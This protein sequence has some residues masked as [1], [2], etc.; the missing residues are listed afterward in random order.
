MSRE[1]FAEQ[2]MAAKL[3]VATLPVQYATEPHAD[4]R[5]VFEV[6]ATYALGTQEYNTFET[7]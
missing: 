5:T 1:D 4:L 7:H 3:L 6:Y 2:F